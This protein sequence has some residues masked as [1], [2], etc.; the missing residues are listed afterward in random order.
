MDS[1]KTVNSSKNE[2]KNNR[3][4]RI[5]PVII[6]I[7]LPVLYLVLFYFTAGYIAGYPFPQVVEAGHHHL[8]YPPESAKYAALY[9]ALL[10]LGFVI[11]VQFVVIKNFT[12]FKKGLLIFLTVLIFFAGI[13]YTLKL[14]L[15]RSVSRYRPHP[16]LLWELRPGKQMPG[17]VINSQGLRCAEF[18]VE[19]EPGEY[20]IL[21]IGDSSAFGAGIDDGFRFSDILEN[22]LRAEYP[23]RKIRVINGAVEGYSIYLARKL[24]ELKL[25]KYNPDCLII[26]FNNDPNADIMQD[27]DRLP[28]EWIVPFY[29]VLYKSDL[30]LLLKKLT[31]NRFLETEQGRQ[32][33]ERNRNHKMESRV[34]DD[35]ISSCYA[36]FINEMKRNGGQ[37]IIIAMP[38]PEKGMGRDELTKFTLEAGEKNTLDTKSSMGKEITYRLLLKK[39]AKENEGLFLDIYSQWRK[40]K[41]NN[42]LFIDHVHPVKEG[43]AMIAEELNK[44][45]IDN[46]L[47]TNQKNDR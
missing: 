10:M 35:D 28:P 1:E 42:S 31:L 27:R 47:I 7:A 46:R 45:I 29:T 33:W 4:K 25:R 23:Q 6:Q 16:Q 38:L 8:Q 36:W 24:Y 11:L 34:S 44:L 12:G 15:S 9:S 37:T 5:L 30:F 39:T 22:K 26:S 13:E 40:E 21:L 43:H 41:D 32:V 19:K 18:P 3:G 14:H 17:T 2:N 20:R